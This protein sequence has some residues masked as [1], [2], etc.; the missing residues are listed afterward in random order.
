MLSNEMPMNLQ[1]FAEEGSPAQPG[2]QGSDGG[3]SGNPTGQGNGTQSNGKTL[4]KLLKQ[5]LM[6]AS[7]RITYGLIMTT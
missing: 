1:Y 5:R 6:A 3:E 2:A 7:G 4:M